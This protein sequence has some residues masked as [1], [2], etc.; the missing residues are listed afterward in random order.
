MQL[1]FM[2]FLI[3]CPLCLLAGFVDAI[4]G[5]GG[6]ISL[7]A[8][9]IAGLP[10]HLAIGTNRI[11]SALGSTVAAVKYAKNGYV[12]WKTAGICLSAAILGSFAGAKA[13][14]FINE[15]HFLYFMLV[16]LP[17]TGIY[18]LFNHLMIEE[19]DAYPVVKTRLLAAVFSFIVG[20]YDGFY[21]PG[22]GIFLLLLLSGA[23]HM[24]LKES[25]GICKL[26]FMVTNLTAFFVFLNEGKMIVSLGLA[27]G[28]FSML[29]NYLGARCFEKA[30]EK[31]LKSLILL[32]L[33]IF[34]VKVVTS[35][36]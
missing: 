29:G 33:L 27:A 34:I 5:G 31:F 6:L 23:A 13:A 1:T 28:I 3:V 12:P 32:V 30:N 25:N 4:V 10:A 20:A 21:G 2:H 26:I 16:L 22:S 35:I 17:L 24:S 36:F 15:Q 7:P 9:L 8:Y 11:N 14:L 18:V 19:K